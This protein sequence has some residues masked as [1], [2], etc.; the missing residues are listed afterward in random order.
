[1]P[2][3]GDNVGAVVAGVLDADLDEIRERVEKRLPAL[4]PVIERL[5]AKDPDE[6]YSTA[7]EVIR[8]VKKLRMQ[9]PEEPRVKDWLDSI[10]EELPPAPSNGDFGD[11]GPPRSIV[12]ANQSLAQAPAIEEPDPKAKKRKKVRKP[13]PKKSPVGVVLLV[14]LLLVFVGGGA[15]FMGQKGDVVA[16]APTPTSQPTSQPTSALPI[17]PVQNGTTFVACTS[18]GSGDGGKTCLRQGIPYVSTPDCDSQGGVNLP[19]P[20]RHMPPFPPAAARPRPPR[21]APPMPS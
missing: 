2:F 10:G 5:M 16:V 14:L 4:V 3:P 8:E 17:N 19:L 15:W 11:D 6:R 21:S 18:Y 12:E 9:L 7:R 20:V 13:P 1:V